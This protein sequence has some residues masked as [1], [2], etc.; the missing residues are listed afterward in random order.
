VVSAF[1]REVAR[2][3]VHCHDYHKLH[4][5]LRDRFSLEPDKTLLADFGHSTLTGAATLLHPYH[6]RSVS[7]HARPL[8][9]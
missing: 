3:S 5:D 1:V 9:E 7:T 2:I 6:D 4:L 8:L